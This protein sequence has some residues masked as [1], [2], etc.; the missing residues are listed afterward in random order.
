MRISDFKKIEDGAAFMPGQSAIRNPHSAIEFSGARGRA[1][2]Y[3]FPRN[4]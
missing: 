4:P 1:V 2:W 3:K